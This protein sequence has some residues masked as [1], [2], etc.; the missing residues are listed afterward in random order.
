MYIIP[1][2]NP[3][4]DLFL[5]LN[6]CYSS[7]TTWC[8]STMSDINATLQKLTAQFESLRED[9]NSI[10]QR[11]SKKKKRKSSRRSAPDLEVGKDATVLEVERD[12]TCLEEG[13]D[14]S[15]KVEKVTRLVPPVPRAGLPREAEP[16]YAPQ[17]KPLETVRRYAL[18]VE[19]ATDRDPGVGVTHNHGVGT[20]HNLEAGIIPV[21][22]AEQDILDL[23]VD[24]HTRRLGVRPGKMY[25][26][27]QTTVR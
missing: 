23:E 20:T 17:T 13:K 3:P 15:L 1:Q 27:I 9:V 5:S 24:P 22:E 2:S 10:K 19:Q 11:K 26:T 18:E 14:H 6:K 25:L 4:I 12:P 21:P 7:R 16:D 8:I